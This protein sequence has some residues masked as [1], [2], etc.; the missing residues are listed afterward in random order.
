M[1]RNHCRVNVVCYLRIVG[2]GEVEDVET[3]LRSR[4]D[5]GPCPARGSHGADKLSIEDIPPRALGPVVPVDDDDDDDDEVLWARCCPGDD[6]VAIL[7]QI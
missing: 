4:R 3:A 1:K 5:D 2:D 6:L 7:Q